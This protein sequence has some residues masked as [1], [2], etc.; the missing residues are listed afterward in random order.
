MVAATAV[1][2]ASGPVAVTG[3]SGFI[4]SWIVEDCVRQGYTVRACVR[5]RSNE[6]KVAHLLAL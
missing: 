5:D 2:P 1:S 4:G 6:K 3:A